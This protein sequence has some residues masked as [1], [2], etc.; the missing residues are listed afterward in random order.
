MGSLSESN[1]NGEAGC[2][3][4]RPASDA[5]LRADALDAA[6]QHADAV[7]EL[8]A[9]ARRRDVDALTRLGRRLLVGDRAPALPRDGTEP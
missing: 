3:G 4:A 9:A 2:G 8:A 1:A 7:N 5:V 6:G